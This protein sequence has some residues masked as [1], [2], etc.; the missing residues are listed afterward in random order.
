M[1]K[2]RYRNKIQKINIK[3]KNKSYMKCH[4][5]K[6]LISRLL[7]RKWTFRFLWPPIVN[8]PHMI[9][10]PQPVGKAL[11]AEPTAVRWA[12]QQWQL[13]ALAAGGHLVAFLQLAARVART[14]MRGCGGA[15][16][17]LFSTGGTL[18][19]NQLKK[20]RQSFVNQKPELM[21][22]C[23]DSTDR[24]SY[25][26]AGI[27]VGRPLITQGIPRTLLGIVWKKNNFGSKWIRYNIVSIADPLLMDSDPNPDPTPFFGDFKDA[28]KKFPYFFLRTYP[29]SHYLQ[30]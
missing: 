29:Q 17:Y 21:I 26:G 14:D 5:D 25:G 15:A 24:R 19:F 4:L 3:C 8:L 22:F 13:Q 30:S 27:A 28:K 6:G 20:G 11:H 16:A 10:Q 7:R 23:F 18:L 2:Q 12:A 9:P 1:S